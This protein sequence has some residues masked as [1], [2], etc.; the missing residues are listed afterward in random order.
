MRSRD[1]VR[2]EGGLREH[3]TGITAPDADRYALTR[4][5]REHYTARDRACPGGRRGRRPRP[6]SSRPRPVRHRHRTADGGTRRDDRERRAAPHPGRARF[7]RHRPGV[8]RQRLHPRL[9][10]PAAARRPG[11]RHPRPAPGLHRRHDPVLGGLAAR[12]LRHHAGLAARGPRGAGRRRRGHRPV[13]A[14]P[15]QHHLPGGTAAQPGDGRLLRDEHG[16][17]RGRPDGR[18]PAD[19]LRCPGAGCCS[20][21]CPSGSRPPS[22][23]RGY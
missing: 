20:S 19:H 16:R 18:R 6:A 8:D 5:P 13:G 1:P 4:R 22:S 14:G 15:D 9:R 23:R 3:C 10:R 11:R 17:R 21:T 7:L 2:I 12:R